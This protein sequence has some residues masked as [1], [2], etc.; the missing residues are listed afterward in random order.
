MLSHARQ[1]AGDRWGKRGHR[2]PQLA[3]DAVAGILPLTWVH[4]S[5]EGD[6][7]AAH[8]GPGPSQLLIQVLRRSLEFQASPPARVGRVLHRVPN[9]N[10]L[11]VFHRPPLSQT[12]VAQKKHTCDEFGVCSEK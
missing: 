6:H 1:H 2:L 12:R 3:D 9:L 5:V 11:V 8:S 7:G 4:Q 10:G